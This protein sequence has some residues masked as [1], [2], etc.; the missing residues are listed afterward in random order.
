M[1]SNYTFVVEFSSR[2]RTMWTAQNTWRTCCWSVTI[3][4]VVCVLIVCSVLSYMLTFAF[5][6]YNHGTKFWNIYLFSKEFVLSCCISEDGGRSSP[7][8]VEAFVLGWWPAASD[9][10]P[11]F[12]PDCCHIPISEF[13]E[14]KLNNFFL[15]DLAYIKIYLFRYKTSNQC[16]VCLQFMLVCR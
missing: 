3:R 6:F 12:S 13:F 2:K 9:H 11:Q 8:N 1:I 7:W 4:Y 14:V 10:R 16:A 5:V 15:W